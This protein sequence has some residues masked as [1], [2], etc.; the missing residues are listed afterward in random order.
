LR[1]AETIM[2]REQGDI[3]FTDDPFL[4]RRHALIRVKNPDGPNPIY[5]LGDME[6]SNGTFLRIRGEVEIQHGDELRMGQ[7]LFRLDLSGKELAA[8]AKPPVQ[9]AEGS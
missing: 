4:S 8:P 3:V 1:K 9:A 2:G 5:T 7:Q 6:S